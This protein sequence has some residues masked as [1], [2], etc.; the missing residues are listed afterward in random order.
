MVHIN[1]AGFDFATVVRIP[2]VVLLLVTI[3]AV[4]KSK[5]PWT[6]KVAK[7]LIWSSFGVSVL[8]KA[9]QTV[10]LLLAGEFTIPFLLGFG[11]VHIAIFIYLFWLHCQAK[12]YS[13]IS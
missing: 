3:I 5:S 7:I 12:K 8:F 13:N 4:S 1:S 2:F 10:Q 6:D 9:I 11:I